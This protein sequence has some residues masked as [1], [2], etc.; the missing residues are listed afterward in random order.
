[1]E[2]I[3]GITIDELARKAG[4]LNDTLI[5]SILAKLIIIIELIHKEGFV[6][7]DIK[8]TNIIITPIGE[9]YIVDFG[10]V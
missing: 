3:D 6:H 1:M 9:I 4:R 8:P 5:I 2:L 10:S 7:M